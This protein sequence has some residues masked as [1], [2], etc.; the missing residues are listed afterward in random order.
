[1]E[2]TLISEMLVSY[3][4]STRHHNAE[5]RNLNLRRENLKCRTQFSVELSYHWQ[6]GYLTAPKHLQSLLNISKS[7]NSR[8]LI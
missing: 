2:A 1:M 6:I 4:N 3:H 8:K 7:I 5:D